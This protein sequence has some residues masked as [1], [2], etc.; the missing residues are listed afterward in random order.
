MSNYQVVDLVDNINT[1]I[2]KINEN[3]ALVDSNITNIVTNINQYLDSDFIRSIVGSD[4]DRITVF[5]STGLNIIYE[6]VATAN[7][8]LDAR[9]DQNSDGLSIIAQ[10]YTNL[11][12]RLF[13]AESDIDASAIARQ[14]LLARID[15]NSDGLS[16]LAQDLTQLEASFVGGL[17]IDSDLVIQA[18]GGAISSLST[19]IDVDSARLTLVNQNLVALSGRVDIFDSGFVT[20][21]MADAVETLTSRIDATDSDISVT[22]GKLVELGGQIALFDS[23]FVLGAVANSGILTQINYNSDEIVTLSGRFDSFE[24]TLAN[25]IA[26]GITVSPEAVADAVGGITD[27]LYAKINANDSNIGIITGRFTNFYNTLTLKDGTVFSGNIFDT[28]N[29]KLLYTDSDLKIVSQK[30]TDLKAEI[31]GSP[32]DSDIEFAV[33]TAKSVLNSRIDADS[34]RLTAKSSLITTLTADLGKVSDSNKNTASLVNALNVSVDNLGNSIATWQLTTD[35][36]GVVGGIRH[37]ND[38]TTTS[39]TIQTDQFKIK[40][41]TANVQPFTVSGN[42]VLLSNATVTGKLNIA[43]TGTGGS[44]TM[45]N[46]VMKIFDNAGNP[47]VLFGR[48][49]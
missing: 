38:G 5:D 47:R 31:N 28:L 17:S 8:G 19:R 43:S 37:K 15:K 6:A 9:I 20:N 30:V 3:F 42:E 18:I 29:T 12:A 1:A 45:T 23:G 25:A 16:I 22:N 13:S 10:S 41:S 35:V 49:G 33:S 36:N 2:D 46:D 32:W 21:V 14:Q 26:D 27:D 40:G 39:F 4:S 11:S 34:A 48:I 24:T 7:Q 44:M